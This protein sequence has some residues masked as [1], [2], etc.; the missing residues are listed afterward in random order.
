MPGA[1][2]GGLEVMECAGLGHRLFTLARRWE[3]LQTFRPTK[4]AFQQYLLGV[5]IDNVEVTAYN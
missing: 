4:Q 3:S 5:L 2:A 1:W